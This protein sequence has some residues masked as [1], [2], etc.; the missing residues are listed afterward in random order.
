MEEPDRAC[1]PRGQPLSEQQWKELIDAGRALKPILWRR[2]RRFR[3][4][5]EDAVAEAVM[6]VAA[7]VMKGAVDYPPTF[8]A[9]L[10]ALSQE[11]TTFLKRE[12]RHCL[13]EA[14]SELRSDADTAPH[15][16]NPERG[17]IIALDVQAAISKLS[18]KL[19]QAVDMVYLHD[20]SLT[21]AAKEIGCTANTLKQRLLRARNK[22]KTLLDDYAP[23]GGG[24]GDT[25]NPKNSISDGSDPPHDSADHS[26]S[27]VHE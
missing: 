19:R 23:R 21:Q 26:N 11:A 14:P 7:K 10:E 17:L 3:S 16:H 6:N 13:R 8:N 1:C 2:W 27:Q 15:S 5:I 24:G 12:K 9:R 18:P 25:S 20:Q 22:L 4:S